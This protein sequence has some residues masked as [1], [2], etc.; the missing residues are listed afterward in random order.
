MGN[1]YRF[2]CE[3]CNVDFDAI[4]GVG[5]M[6]PMLYEETIQKGKAGQLGEDIQ[7]FLAENPD[8]AL[9]VSY[10]PYFC[11]KCGTLES[12]LILTMYLPKNKEYKNDENQGR[13]SEAFSGEGINYDAPWDLKELYKFHKI[14]LHYCSQCGSRT[15]R[16]TEQ[17][18]T[19]GIRCPSCGELMRKSL[20]LWD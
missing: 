16:L 17:E 14:H 11:K 2:H 9:D 10:A 3:K 19:A 4:E 12:K 20:I 13:W 1:G 15:K 18:L 6:F 7:H 5:M 8:G